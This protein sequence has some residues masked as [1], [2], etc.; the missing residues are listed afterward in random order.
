[1]LQRQ[2]ALQSARISQSFAESFGA[3][4]RRN[5][6]QLA[7]TAKWAT[8][9]LTGLTTAMAVKGVKAGLQLNAQFEAATAGIATFTGSMSSAARHIERL[10]KVSAQ[11]PLRLTS[12]VEASRTLQG[13]GLEA[14]KTVP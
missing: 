3:A 6:Q 13:F 5:L 9:I 1:P 11:S 2:A 12:C 7:T 4:Q 8:G 10:R 14:E